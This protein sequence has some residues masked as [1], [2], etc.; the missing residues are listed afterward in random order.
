M[1]KFLK[2]AAIATK[3]FFGRHWKLSSAILL[4]LAAAALVATAILL[5]PGILASFAAFTV[6]GAAPLA[7]L[8]GL[9][10]A[11]ATAACAGMAAGLV[12]VSSAAFNLATSISNWLDRVFT[13]APRIDIT[14]GPTSVVIEEKNTESCTAR[15]LNRLPCTKE[16]ASKLEIA[17]EEAVH[18]GNVLKSVRK[19]APEVVEQVAH[20][21]GYAM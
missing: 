18:Y 11:G 17:E 14:V 10:F 6:F 3:D 9:S 13:P 20:T 19:N 16:K 2:N 8:T 7:F 21:A 1:F 5:F 4:A 12:L 15:M